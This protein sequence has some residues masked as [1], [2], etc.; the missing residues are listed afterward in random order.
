MKYINRHLWLAVAILTSAVSGS[1]RAGEPTTKP[2]IDFSAAGA[3]SRIEPDF[4][5]KEQVE[6]KIVAGGKDKVLEVTIPPG[7]AGFPG[8]RIKPADKVWDLSAYGHVE[9]RIVNTG[10]NP[11]DLGLRVDNA[12]DW[13]QS[14]WNTE[15]THLKPGQAAT[16]RVVFG[17]SYGPKPGYALQPEAVVN[18]LLFV[19]KSDSVQSFRID[20]VTAGGHP[21]EKP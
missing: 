5:S 6:F 14:P 10:A 15:Q 1:L 18:V 4:H 20:S 3:E 16:V 17:Y 7:S 21:G 9:A 8:V 19:T 2:L 13:R 11:L 12:G